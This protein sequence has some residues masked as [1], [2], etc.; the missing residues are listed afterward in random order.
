M[1]RTTTTY[2]YKRPLAIYEDEEDDTPAR[3]RHHDTG[4]DFKPTDFDWAEDAEDED[5]IQVRKAE[6]ARLK[7]ENDELEARIKAKVFNTYAAT[8]AASN[9]TPLP[10][11]F[12]LQQPI[13]GRTPVGTTTQPSQDPGRDGGRRSRRGPPRG[14]GYRRGRDT[15]PG[16]VPGFENLP[17]PDNHRLSTQD[18]SLGRLT[19]EQ[20]QVA[21]NWVAY[22]QNP[23]PPAY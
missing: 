14:G 20:R 13:R 7:A 15:R 6:V 4:N 23:D 22:R 10:A 21:E 1:V 19:E 11:K 17:R 12:D 16:G 18:P 2:Y 3:K 5:Q 8:A 9:T